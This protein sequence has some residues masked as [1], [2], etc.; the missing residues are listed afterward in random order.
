MAKMRGIA[1]SNL[2]LYGFFALVMTIGA[3]VLW[4][5]PTWGGDG[6]LAFIDALFTSV[7]AVAVTGLITANTAYFTQLGQ[8][9][10]LILIQLGGL[11][12]IAL[13]TIALT[14]P[15]K[16]I[17]LQRRAI[18]RQ[19]YIGSVEYRPRRIV[20]NIVL[21]TLGIELVIFLLLL[22]GFSASG[23]AAP[24]WAALFHAVS[25]FCNA[26]F[27][28]FADSLETFAGNPAI[29]GP[30]MLALVLGGLGFVVY[31][32]FF[33]RAHRHRHVLSV[34][35]RIVIVATITL[36]VSGFVVF[37]VTE[38][39][40]AFK[41]LSNGDKLFAAL[42]QSVTPRT[43]GFNT[44]RQSELSAPGT[45]MTLFL[46]I[47]GGAPGSIAGGVKVTTVFIALFAAFGRIDQA[48]NERVFR[49]KIPADLVARANRFLIRAVLLLLFAFFML[50]VTE[51]LIAE[52]AFTFRELTF[53][54]F[55]AFGTVGLSLGITDQLSNYGKLIIILTMFA[56]RVSLISLAIPPRGKNW[57][58]SV[59]YPK[60]EVIIG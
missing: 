54:T 49:R 31:Q 43:A 2:Y 30:V 33:R 28:I 32:D 35:T 29:T 17:S 41:D 10:I 37:L 12:I 13:S 4:L 20:R 57:Q 52:K 3:F 7:S 34:H 50:T 8:V 48:G 38:W 14:Q 19:Y 39:N 26:G 6:E 59:D 11:G 22:P 18:I 23:T 5:L 27:S 36:I 16:R 42:F 15:E 45:T 58:A 25:A 51:I 40:N 21:V 46:M 24:V 44:V 47:I 9:I 56:G 53:E 55:S 60:G 1:A